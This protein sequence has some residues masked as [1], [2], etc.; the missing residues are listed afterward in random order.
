MTHLSPI[1]ASCATVLAA[2]ALC[3]ARLPG[4][5]SNVKLA[6]VAGLSYSSAV[7]YLL[8]FAASNLL[9]R[10]STGWMGKHP[11]G[12]ISTFSWAVL[13]PYHLGLRIKLGVQRLLGTEPL[14][15]HILPGWYLGGWPWHGDQLPPGESPSVLDVTCELPRTHRNRYLCL[16]VW[17]TQAP[18]ASQIDHGVAFCLA[19]RNMNRTIYVHCAHGHGRSALL[20]IACLLEAGHVGSVDEGLAVLQAAR[21][22]VKLNARQRR[23]L[24]AWL[25]ARKGVQMQPL[26]T[27]AALLGARASGNGNG[28]VHVHAHAHGHGHVHGH[29]GGAEFAAPNGIAGAGA[30]G[31]RHPSSSEALGAGGVVAATGTATSPH[32]LEYRVASG[33]SAHGHASSRSSLSGERT[34][35]LGPR[36]DGGLQ[37]AQSGGGGAGAGSGA[38]A[39][40]S[41]LLFGASG[42]GPGGVVA[43]VGVG[44]GAKKLS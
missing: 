24:E 20:L 34:E 10:K 30:H 12:T 18:T 14:Y 4:P 26:G 37:M 3:A 36:G 19:E 16:P 22:R 21:P 43:V 27:E 28:H 11:N 25:R 33:S 41:G 1:V 17:D 44:E 2:S 13:A 31:H 6:L 5:N 23:A 35:L 42:A 8:A 9:A 39:A 40:G 7:G 29:G 15:D 38:L 32:V